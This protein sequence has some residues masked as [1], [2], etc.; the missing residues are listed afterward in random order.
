MFAEMRPSL[1][2][3]RRDWVIAL[4]GVPLVAVAGGLLSS[5]D[6]TH[7]PR[8]ESIGGDV[9]GSRTG[10]LDWWCRA[11]DVVPVAIAALLL[12]AALTALGW[13]LGRRR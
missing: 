6:F 8:N 13:G 7:V 4:L 9:G 12:I 5:V 3:M 2:E 1:V 10:C 11:E